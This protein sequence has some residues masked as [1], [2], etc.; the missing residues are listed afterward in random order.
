M[1]APSTKDREFDALVEASK[2]LSCNDLEVI[3]FAENRTETHQGRTI[4][5]TNL[6]VY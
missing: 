6:E 3:T 1:R 4:R 2:E 5:V